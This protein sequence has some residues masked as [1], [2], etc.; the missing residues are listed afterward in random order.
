[1]DGSDYASAVYLLEVLCPKARVSRWSA[2][3]HCLCVRQH[4]HLCEICQAVG[5]DSGSR[6]PSGSTVVGARILYVHGIGSIGGAERDL[7]AL[8]SKLDRRIWHPTIACPETGPLREVA[9][10]QDVPTY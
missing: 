3:T 1:M 6:I 9:L 10:A 2:R 7:I 8:L 4:V 5:S